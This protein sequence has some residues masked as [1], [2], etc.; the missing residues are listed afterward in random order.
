MSRTYAD[1]RIKEALRR[2]N[3]H[4]LKARQ[5]VIAWT[6]EDTKLLH[7]LTRP[8]LLGIVAHAVNR[9]ASEMPEETG[10]KKAPPPKPKKET[11][12]QQF[13]KELLKVLANGDPAIFGQEN[14]S[15]PAK[16]TRASQRHVDTLRTISEKSGE[17]KV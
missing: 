10:N 6:Y 1:N 11:R 2:N 17:K 4:L 14:F 5:Q 9:I 15:P 12:D 13:G 3:G 8:H 16:S 7:E